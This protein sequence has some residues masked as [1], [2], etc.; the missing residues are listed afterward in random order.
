MQFTGKLVSFRALTVSEKGYV[1][2][3]FEIT[4]KII[5]MLYLKKGN[6]IFSLVSLGTQSLQTILT[7]KSD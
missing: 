7:H 3:I 4:V 2:V 6:I 1:C 5:F